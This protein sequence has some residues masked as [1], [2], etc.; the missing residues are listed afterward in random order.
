M[1]TV[2]PA[3]SIRVGALE[4]SFRSVFIPSILGSFAGEWKRKGLV[5]REIRT[6]EF[7]GLILQTLC[8]NS[9]HS[10]TPGSNPEGV[11]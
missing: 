1:S 6:S 2:P 9:R 8:V 10:F 11:P 3:K 5:F 4:R 7:T